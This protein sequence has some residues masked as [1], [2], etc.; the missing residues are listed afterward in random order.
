MQEPSQP[1]PESAGADGHDGQPPVATTVRLWDP[2]VRAFHWLLA[3]AFA[4]GWYLGEFR[5]FTT[6]EW[7]FWL[8]Y[9]I[10]GLVVLRLI[11]GLVGPPSARLSA[12]FHSPS[13]TWNYVRTLGRREPSRY[14]GHNP[15]GSLAI[16]ALLTSLS[17]QVLT[18]LFAEDDGLFSAGPLSY[19]IDSG[20]VAEINAIHHYNSRLLIAMVALHL[21]AIAYY[22]LWKRENL[23]LAMITG[24]KTVKPQD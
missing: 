17:V 19:L 22:A 11:W 13:A 6:I 14:P 1:L 4:V 10:G 5:S 20:W 18:G 15:L 7:H 3:I 2:I 9:G 21:G 16:L 8:G 12:L 24:R 23:I